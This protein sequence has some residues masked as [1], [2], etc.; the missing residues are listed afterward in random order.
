MEDPKRGILNIHP[1]LG[2]LSTMNRMIWDWACNI[3]VWV[4]LNHV[5]C[6]IDKSLVLHH[7]VLLQLLI[8]AVHVHWGP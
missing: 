4:L 6:T 5:W 2:T 7:I 1:T 3:D 8:E